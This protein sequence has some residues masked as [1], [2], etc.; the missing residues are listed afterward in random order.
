[1]SQ[2]TCYYKV[3]GIDNQANRED[4]ASA[5]REAA[6]KVHPTRHPREEFPTNMLK[7]N[8]MCEAYHV[9]QDEKLRFIYDKHGYQSLR[10]GIPSGD[11]KFDGYVYRGEAF[12]IFNE[13][14][15]FSNPHCE[16]FGSLDPFK[17][18]NEK[19]AADIEQTLDCTLHEMY[20][21]AMK[22]VTF[23]RTKVHFDGTTVETIKE[24]LNI[25]IKP[26]FGPQTRLVFPGR[27][28]ELNGA[29]PSDLIISLR[30]TADEHFKRQGN[31]LIYIHK[32]SLVDALQPKPFH[33]K[34][35]DGRC[36]ALNPPQVVSPQTRIPIADEG[37]PLCQTGNVVA[38]VS[39]QILPVKGQAKGCL[40]V[41]FDI[42]FPQRI[43]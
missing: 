38:D 20:N 10:G 37:M 29:L 33:V 28:D 12:R 8:Q 3:L 24:T 40:Y 31:D 15:G 39:A 16:E 21:G 9:L 42:Q 17:V 14:F 11:D 36:L 6:P 25:E 23:E 41:E 32:L 18:P 2:P 7:L 4:I 26:G 22:E 34:T 30:Q 13:F 43:L 19:R 1:M 35:L 27:G 5:F